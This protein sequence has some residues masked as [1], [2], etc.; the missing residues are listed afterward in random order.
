MDALVKEL[1]LASANL[2]EAAQPPVAQ[3]PTP[4]D[5]MEQMR[6]AIKEQLSEEMSQIRDVI[7]P[8]AT[9]HATP[10]KAP[11]SGALG[12]PGDRPL[13]EEDSSKTCRTPQRPLAAWKSQL[14]NA[15]ASP[16]PAPETKED[17]D[18]GVNAAGSGEEEEE[19]AAERV[20][21]EYL[22]T[23]DRPTPSPSPSPMAAPHHPRDRELQSLAHGFYESSEDLVT[24]MAWIARYLDRLAAHV[25]GKGKTAPPE[26]PH[27]T[28]F[29]RL[30]RK[31]LAKTQA[32]E[33]AGRRRMKELYGKPELAAIYTENG[34]VGLW[35]K[36]CAAPEYLLALQ[37][38]VAVTRRECQDK[39][40]HISQEKEEA[41]V[42]CS[43]EWKRAIRTAAKRMNKEQGHLVCDGNIEAP[44]S[45]PAV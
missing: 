2:R 31:L 28:D 39:I 36:Q 29:M 12:S 3:A 41:L 35:Q 30:L 11:P 32:A 10:V 9:P 44:M 21:D 22:G 45:P 15:A 34:E 16:A 42:K 19:P 37:T 17:R 13:V 26:E 6:A 27:N 8:L 20:V 24:Q 25:A 38:T 33:Q 18:G 5:F 43:R 7:T 1:S 4:G 40:H 14:G 23:G